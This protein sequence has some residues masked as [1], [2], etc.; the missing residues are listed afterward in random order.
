M[1]MGEKP[2]DPQMPREKQP[3]QAPETAVI[4]AKDRTKDRLR[5]GANTLMTGPMGAAAA[6]TQKKTLL[7]G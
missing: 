2:K 6:P 4:A 3:A 1:C 7:G 5:A